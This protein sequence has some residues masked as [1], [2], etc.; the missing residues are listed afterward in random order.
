MF[1]SSQ[2]LFFSFQL[3]TGFNVTLVL[4]DDSVLFVFTKRKEKRKKMDKMPILPNYIRNSI[5]H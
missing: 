5:M 2:K 1:N 3:L 4:V